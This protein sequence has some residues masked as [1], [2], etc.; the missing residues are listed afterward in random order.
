MNTAVGV[1]IFERNLLKQDSRRQRFVGGH[2]TRVPPGICNRF[3]LRS[4]TG[5]QDV[6][7]T[8]PRS[9][10]ETS[11]HCQSVCHRLAGAQAETFTDNA[12]VRSVEPQ[13]ENVTVPRNECSSHWVT[14]ERAHRRRAGYGGAVMGG[15]AGGILGHQVG[16]GPRQG[17]RHRRRRGGGRLAGDRLEN[18]DRAKRTNRYRARSSACRT[19]YD[20]QTTHHGLSRRLR[21]P[22]P[23]LQH[24]HARQPGQE[25]ARCACRST[26]SGGST[27]AWMRR[28][29][30][31]P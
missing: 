2:R 20:V 7:H 18:R 24:L 1:P 10:H 21:V 12:R 23:A 25:P 11:C 5:V 9:L 28:P 8:N 19:V 30:I 26:R 6:I 15:V 14:E 16:G 3:S 29:A 31:A 4:H 13:Y 27:I 22:G 17:R